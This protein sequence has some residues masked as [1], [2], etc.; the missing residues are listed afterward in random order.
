MKRRPL[1][2]GLF[3]IATL[4]IALAAGAMPRRQTTVTPPPELARLPAPIVEAPPLPPPAVDD[5]RSTPAPQQPRAPRIE[6]VFALDTTGSME[7]LIAGAKRKIWSIANFIAEAQPKPEVRI[8]L[9]GYRDLGD[10]Y[11]TRFYDLSDDMDTVFK[12]LSSFRAEGGGDTPEHV[13]RAL[14]DAVERTSWSQDGQVVKIVYLVG[15][16]PPH[17]DYHDGYDYRAI[18]RHAGQKGIHINTVLCG[19]DP[20]AKVAWLEIAHA[21]HGEYASIAQSGGVATVATPF[22]DRLAEL[23]RRLVGT[24]LG[25]GAHRREIAEKTASALSA[26]RSI[27]ADRA[28]FVAA[29]GMAVSGE[30]DLLADVAKGKAKLGAIPAASLPAPMQAMSPTEQNAYVAAKQAERDKVIDEIKSVSHSRKDFM[31]KE[32]SK[33]GHA[34]G[35]D[36]EVRRSITRDTAGVLSF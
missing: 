30:G 27:A 16:A 14:H 2:Y 36:D 34:A 10:A 12:H 32:S 3:A 29:G 22:D 8:G 31:K 25:Y 4:L 7:G 11:V 35:F 21:G 23:N 9:V 15:D 20:E 19:N 1:T 17:T 33:P 5:P 26:P 28:G 24:A 13:A 6:V 18:A